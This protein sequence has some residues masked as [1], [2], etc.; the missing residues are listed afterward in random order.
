MYVCVRACVCM[1]VCIYRRML[2]SMDM[3]S[4]TPSHASLQH[5]LAFTSHSPHDPTPSTHSHHLVLT[6]SL[7]QSINHSI[8]HHLVLTHSLNHSLTHSLTPPQHMLTKVD[9]GSVSGINGVEWDA[10]ELPSQF[11]QNWWGGECE[12]V[13]ACVRASECVRE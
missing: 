1:C 7:N 8:N 13:S 4:V 12:R 10:V 5:M 6:H 9:V 11:M 3:G 2:I